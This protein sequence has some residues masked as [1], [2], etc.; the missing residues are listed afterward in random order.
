M[1]LFLQVSVGNEESQLIKKKMVST[2]FI[3]FGVFFFSM[4][5]NAEECATTRNGLNQL[6]NGTPYSNLLT[7]ANWVNV[8]NP[9]GRGFDLVFNNGNL[10]LASS[11][12]LV[13]R[14]FVSVCLENN[15]LTIRT[16]VQSRRV[17]FQNGNLVIGGRTY[18]RR[19]LQS[20]R[21]NGGFG[22][23]GISR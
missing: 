19:D 5:T 8:N 4:D 13:G 18:S 21:I 22:S 23:L 1:V 2:F 11:T 12:A 7:S 15:R 6:L 3:V 9:N 20:G 14:K 16:G 17:S 10:Y